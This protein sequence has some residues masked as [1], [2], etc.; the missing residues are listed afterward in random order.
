MDLFLLQ[1]RENMILCTFRSKN[2][3]D[4]FI[5]FHLPSLASEEL[6]RIFLVYSISEVLAHLLYFITDNMHTQRHSPPPLILHP[7]SMLFW[8]YDLKVRASTTSPVPPSA[9]SS[10][11]CPNVLFRGPRSFPPL[12]IFLKAGLQK[13]LSLCFLCHLTYPFTMTS[14][15]LCSLFSLFLVVSN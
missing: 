1:I 13:S 12:L 7:S 9:F 15:A 6:Y 3:V 5:N 2:N 11:T 8:F 10:V 4:C 14:W